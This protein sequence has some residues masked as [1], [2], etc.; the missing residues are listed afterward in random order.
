MG[1]IV[2]WC[3]KYNEAPYSTQN[4]SSGKSFAALDPNGSKPSAALEHDIESFMKM[5]HETSLA[6]L[7]VSS[8]VPY[9]VAGKISVRGECPFQTPFTHVFLT[10]ARIQREIER[11]TRVNNY[12]RAPTTSTSSR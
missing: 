1:R 5:D 12:N 4:E 11:K 6:L 9:L 8:S 2:D 7:M 3:R 10:S